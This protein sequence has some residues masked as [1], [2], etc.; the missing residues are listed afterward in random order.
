MLSEAT[1]VRR[2]NDSPN[3]ILASLIIA[4]MASFWILLRFR[5]NLDSNRI[6]ASTLHRRLLILSS[7]LAAS[8]LYWAVQELEFTLSL[9]AFLVFT[10]FLGGL[11]SSFMYTIF[12]DIPDDQW[13]ISISQFKA[14][15]VLFQTFFLILFKSI[16]IPEPYMLLLLTAPFSLVAA[17]L[18]SGAPISWATLKA[19]DN[20][21]D[22]SYGLVK[23]PPRGSELIMIAM[24]IGGLVLAK[25]TILKTSTQ[26]IAELLVPYSLG[27]IA[28]SFTASLSPSIYL[29]QILAVTTLAVSSLVSPGNVG[30]QLV[31]LGAA[32]GYSEIAT[33]L[34]V[35]E[36]R[37]RSIRRTMTLI[38]IWVAAAAF[39]GGLAV[40]M[41]G[42]PVP[43]VGLVLVGLG[44]LVRIVSASRE[45]RARWSR[46]DYLGEYP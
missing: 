41:L 22:A 5:G 30:I 6:I 46:G 42:R 35:L 37:P 25:L 26:P 13:R 32:L 4:G 44:I 28:G 29:A 39:I 14:Y 40:Y 16:K 27:Y 19:L 15:T 36:A 43:V 31:L 23:T 7:P 9:A 2:L 18:V 38:T 11:V 20:L 34:S 8:I 10:L 12:R 1:L 33:I 24:G 21:I 3:S 17:S 45:R